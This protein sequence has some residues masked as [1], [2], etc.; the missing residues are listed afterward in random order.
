MRFAYKKF[1]TPQGLM[2]AVCDAEILG[3]RLQ[4]GNLE[5]E[6][7]EDFYFERFCSTEE[8]VELL[9]KAKIVNLFGNKIMEVVI[10]INLANKEDFKIIDNIPHIQIYKL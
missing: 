9:K 10:K 6:I 5:I 2:I 7:S 1:D 4:H 8:I 3:K